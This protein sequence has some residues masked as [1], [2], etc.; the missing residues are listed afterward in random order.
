MSDTT[1]SWAC[2]HQN[3]QP[4]TR[5]SIQLYEILIRFNLRMQELEKSRAD[6]RTAREAMQTA[7]QQ[8]K[9]AISKLDNVKLAYIAR[10]FTDTCVINHNHPHA[11]PRRL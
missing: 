3:P 6:A 4:I 2:P 5:S 11:H 7:E 10:S 9:L 1:T 8:H